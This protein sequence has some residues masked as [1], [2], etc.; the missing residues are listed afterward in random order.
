MLYI[1]IVYI[2]KHTN[3]EDEISDVNI[4]QNTS[5]HN[6]AAYPNRIFSWLV[7]NS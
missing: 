4:L 3:L 6:L 5:K 2:Q 1:E 7:L